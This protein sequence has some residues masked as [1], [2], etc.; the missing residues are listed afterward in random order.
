MFKDIAEAYSVLSDKDKR[1]RYDMGV[2]DSEGMDLGGF[3]GG[4]I[5]PFDIFRNIFSGGREDTGDDGPMPGFGGLGGARGFPRAQHFG[6]N[7][8]QGGSGRS[9]GPQQFTFKFG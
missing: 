9:G 1:K 7:P 6:F 3:N 2:D 5:N 4:G 8:F